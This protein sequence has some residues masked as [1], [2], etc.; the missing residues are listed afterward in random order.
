MDQDIVTVVTVTYNAEDLLEDTIL[1]VI[2]QS[3][4]NIEYIVIDGAS[5]DKTVDIIKR[6]EDH[7]DYWVS[8]PDDGIYFAMNKA[9]K[10]ATGKWINF[11]NAGDTFF[12]LNIIQNVMDVKEIDAELIYGNFQIKETKA[13]RKAWDKSEWHFHTPF[14]HQTL[15]TK[16]SL[17]KEELFDTGYRLA[18]DHN[19]FIAMYKKGK[20]F[21]YIDKNLA[22][23]SL[24]GFAESNKLLMN[25]ES[26]KILLDHNVPQ[27]E[28][29]Q[30]DWYSVLSKNIYL[31]NIVDIRDSQD[32]ELTILKDSI[33]E[34]SQ[35]SILKNP[36]KKYR[37]Y[38]KMLLNY[39]KMK[40]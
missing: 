31:E 36:I 26:I 27:D 34:V 39:Y 29:R 2:N 20:N 18:A 14:C 22:I 30:S 32:R 5:S 33:K 40:T 4:D 3:Y 38:K 8:E 16:T 28:I 11:M 24:G 6:Y 21:F 19:F 13:I 35:Y 23:F 12:D 9:I 37:S 10:K 1:S 17:M 25:I 15:F 7:I